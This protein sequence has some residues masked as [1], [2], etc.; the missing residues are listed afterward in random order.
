MKNVLARLAGVAGLMILCSAHVGSPDVWYEGAAGPYH[1]VVYVRLPGVVPGIADI[2]VQ[3]AGDPPDQV[4]AMVNLFNAN[5]GT[6]PPD[7]A[8]PV[9]GGR[10]WYSTRLWIMAPGSN[11]VTVGVRGSKGTGSVIVPV[12]AVPNRRLPLHRSLGIILAGLG[13]FLFAGIVTI[14]GAVVRE[15]V[16]PAGESPSPRRMWGARGAMAGTAVFFGLLLLGGWTW[17][18]GEDQGFQQRM[19]RP[20]GAAASVARDGPRSVLQF[21]ITDSGWAKRGDSVWLSQHHQRAWAPLVTDHGKLMHLFL[22]REGDM[23]AFAHVHPATA[24]SVHFTAPLPPLPPGRYRV[25]ADIVHETGF[26]KTL[27]TSVELPGDAPPNRTG[28]APDDGIYLGSAAAAERATLS[29]GATIRWERGRA[30]LVEGAPA[31]LSFSVYE[32]DGRPASLEPYLG[33]AAHA[34]VARDDGG[35]FIHLH[36]MGTI[37]PASQEAFA[38]QQQGDTVTGAIGSRIAA[39]DSL[40]VAMT[41]PFPSGHVSFP[42]AFPQPGRYRIWIQVKRGGSV[43]TAAFDAEVRTAPGSR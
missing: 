41:H 18:G 23:G 7:V 37:S 39:K 43:Q 3:V 32:A 30:P 42:Y 34:V 11:S 12:A 8:K 28:L 26:A 20:F 31:P 6:P 16:L 27:V 10:G 9:E 25:F 1:I 38:L 36:P 22:I 13:V 2:N 15:S 4:T 24:D 5:A 17:W 21:E 40:M 14:A 33:M 19:Y 29:D 35:V